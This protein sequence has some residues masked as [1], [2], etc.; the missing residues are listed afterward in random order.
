MVRLA[1]LAGV[2][3]DFTAHP[4][5]ESDALFGGRFHGFSSRKIV[6]DAAIRALAAAPDVSA[7]ESRS[8]EI[9]NLLRPRWPHEMPQRK[10]GQREQT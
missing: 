3:L 5:L 4:A 1:E 6:G 2:M 7:R 9:P 8:T 10:S